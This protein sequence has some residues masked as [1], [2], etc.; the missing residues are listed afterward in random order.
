MITAIRNTDIK[1]Q[2]SYGNLSHRTAIPP[3]LVN[4]S[5]MFSSKAAEAG[6]KLIQRVSGLTVMT[7][8]ALGLSNLL[9]KNN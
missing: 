4:E 5:K 9:G 3:T 7:L 8:A 1:S 6:N 2:P